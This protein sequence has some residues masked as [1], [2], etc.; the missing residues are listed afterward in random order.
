MSQDMFETEPVNGPAL[1]AI[2]ASAI[3]TFAMGAL[4]LLAEIGIFEAEA[5]MPQRAG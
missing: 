2:L 5:S 3:G 4:A 1:A